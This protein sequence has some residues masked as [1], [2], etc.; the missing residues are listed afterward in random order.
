MSIREIFPI[1]EENCRIEPP[2]SWVVPGE[3]DWGF[4]APTGSA[5]ALLLVDE[6]Q[7]VPTRS[8]SNRIV[9]QVL[10]A[11]AVQGFREVEIP[12]NPSTHRLGIHDLV[13][14]R[15]DH[16][17]A[18]QP[19]SI[20]SAVEFVF[21]AQEQQV[22]RG[23]VAAQLEPLQAGDAIDLSW[24]LVPLEANRL[25]FTTFHGFVWSVPCGVTHFA[26]HSDPAMPVRCQLHCPEAISKPEQSAAPGRQQWLQRRPPITRFEPDAPPG[27]WNFPVLEASSWSN[28]SQVAEFTHAVWAQALS[29]TTGEIP[30]LVASLQTGPDLAAAVAE[31]IRIVQDQ[32]A[33][34]D[35]G[36]G[37][38][39]GL[40]PQGAGQVLRQRSGNA[41]GK[42][43]LLTV[44]LRELGVEAWPLLVN[45][46]WQDTV[47]A[48]LPS[49]AVFN[50][51]IVTF[52]IDGRRHFVDPWE[53]SQRGN[54]A[55]WVQPAYGFGLEVRPAVAA[56]IPLPSPPRA[57]LTLT[58]TFALD[59][60]GKE[61]CVE[62]VLRATYWL[63][64]EMRESI[65]RDR[66]AFIQAH[67]EALQ[68]Q[69][70]ALL[71]DRE[72]IELREDPD[73]DA[74]EMRGR[75][76]LPTW[77]QPGEPPP[78]EFGYRANGLF[79]AVDWIE[80]PEERTVARALRH[81][82]RV[83]HRVQV[84]G[85]FIRSAKPE[86]RGQAGPGFRY[87]CDV[88]RKQGLATFDH[89]WEST[90]SRVEAAEWLDYCRGIN[91]V[92]E[93]VEISVPTRPTWRSFVKGRPVVFFSLLAV[94][95]VGALGAVAG[96]SRFGLWPV[97]DQRPAQG[98]VQL[99]KPP[100]PPPEVQ[101]RVNMAVDAAAKG[102]LT[103]AA[104]LLEKEQDHYKEDP[105]FQFMRAEVAIRT[106]ELDQARQALEQ[107]KTLD[108]TNVNGE[109][110]TAM[111][112]R[113][114]GDDSEAKDILTSAIRRNPNDPRPLREL[115][116]TLTQE[117]AFQGA[118]EAWA[119]VLE[120]TP[121]D[122]DA[123]RQYAVLLWQ[124][125]E[126]ERADAIINQALAAQ[127]TPNAA[128]EAAA[129]DY[130]TLTG[131]RAEALNRLEKAASLAPGDRTRDFALASGHLRSGQTQQAAE[132]AAKL[133]REFPTDVR[134]W[135]VLAVAKSILNDQPAAE[136][137]YREWMR[138]APQDPNG[139]ANFGF[140]LHQS[141]RN[142]EAK[143]F[144]A[145][146]SVKFPNEGVIWL[147][148]S[149]V[150]EALGE[151]EAAAAAKRK[152]ADLLSDQ[153]KQLL[154]R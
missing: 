62:Q 27:V 23:S 109:I 68:H 87:R 58:E 39:N 38:S 4:D 128:L 40:S 24:T 83:Q 115:A 15:K 145:E 107:A 72:S 49:P 148:Y 122:S 124:G 69:F 14:W 73:A 98:L 95:I 103:S 59:R 129:G 154:I 66:T 140:F 54:L 75:Y 19:R 92:F 90:A 61:G 20:L 82:M 84:A 70:P 111:L 130:F 30:A 104:P 102:D 144:L 34:L 81:P 47:A 126:K 150:L 86:Q 41:E 13:I 117:G 25:P 133:T 89:V 91:R 131:R 50:H 3:P 114:E 18:W 7:H 35:S 151:T 135:Q 146:S 64:D 116:V 139:P 37:S 28:W 142:E 125:G 51:V 74:I 56:L 57:E 32:I 55:R 137:A 76:A 99:P 31:A 67:V 88:S 106:G 110:L 10:S 94:G 85:D 118:S 113:K 123:L 33:D 143:A 16:S 5:F 100:P 8:V 53:A 22:A 9:R 132:L 101:A 149:A 93:L 108:P 45:P 26:I 79:L 2:P 29:D 6:Q 42:A 60:G 153:E 44:L 17:G 11:E 21:V 141:G 78:G 138:L 63:A 127:S 77:G 121:G 96:F 1:S 65:Q 80:H 97:N 120:L 48:V 36:F 136:A 105:A 12:L 119:R 52:A 134:P 46:D 147:N 43:A 71:A 152:A 112:N